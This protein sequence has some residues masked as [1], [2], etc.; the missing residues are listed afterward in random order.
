MKRAVPGFIV[1]ALTRQP[2][3]LADWLAL[4]NRIRRLRHDARTLVAALLASAVAV[5]LFVVGAVRYR[6]VLTDASLYVASHALWAGTLT[7]LYFSMQVSRWRIQAEQR[8]ALSWLTTF[9]F[10]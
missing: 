4:Y 5:S 1:R 6:V 8:H 10:L 2:V 9:P 7:A 3:L